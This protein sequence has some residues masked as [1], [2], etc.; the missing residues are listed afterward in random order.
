MNG[1]DLVDNGF[2]LADYLKDRYLEKG[3]RVSAKHEK[4]FK[5]ANRAKV[6]DF[7]IA[8]GFE[9][10]L[11]DFK[12]PMSRG[13]GYWF[14]NKEKEFIDSIINGSK[15]DKYRFIRERNY[16]KLSDD[17]AIEL[18]HFAYGMMANRGFVAKDLDCRIEGPYNLLDYPVRSIN[19]KIVSVKTELDK[20]QTFMFHQRNQMLT[21]PNDNLAWIEY[22]ETEIQKV[23]SNG[24]DVFGEMREIRNEE[25]F[26]KALTFYEKMSEEDYLQQT[27]E[28]EVSSRAYCI[29]SENPVVQRLEKDE[30]EI[31]G[32][33]EAIRDRVLGDYEP[34]DDFSQKEIKELLMIYRK[35]EDLYDQAHKQAISEIA[36]ERGMPE[37]EVSK[38]RIV[39]DDLFM[40]SKDLLEKAKKECSE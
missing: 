17:D 9:K 38:V 34:R 40:S 14:F 27:L 10:F 31:R 11:D 28:D 19:A 39:G 18:F 33:P 3:E 35:L 37:K 6:T 36:S 12:K 2:F 23:V 21:S 32:I 16:T 7:L 26:N 15:A 30:R 22:I 29:Y 20:V 8:L 1:G 24:I 4:E 5:K 25:I 13:N